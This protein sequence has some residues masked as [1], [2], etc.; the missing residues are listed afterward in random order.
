MFDVLILPAALVLGA[1]AGLFIGAALG[2][3]RQTQLELALEEAHAV[4]EDL[5]L[6]YATLVA[7]TGEAPVLRLVED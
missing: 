3:H 6:D 7:K 1:T 4:L 5:G 2:V